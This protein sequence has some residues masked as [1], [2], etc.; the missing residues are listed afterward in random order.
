M[1]PFFHDLLNQ[2]FR[3]SQKSIDKEIN[4]ISKIYASIVKLKDNSDSNSKDLAKINSLKKQL[5]ASQKEVNRLYDGEQACLD[6]GLVF[7]G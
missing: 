2:I 5:E 1:T 3:A 6:I 4:F 7:G